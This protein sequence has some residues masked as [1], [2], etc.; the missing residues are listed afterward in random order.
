V[1]F[2]R[3]TALSAV[4]FALGWKWGLKYEGPEYMAIVFSIN[5]AW[6]GFLGLAF[7]RCWK[8]SPSFR[9]SLFVHWMLFAWL[10]W[11][12]FRQ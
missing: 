6:V 11:Y 7:R 5:V 8:A 1:L 9:T 12:A 10:C 4:D 3:F 2:A